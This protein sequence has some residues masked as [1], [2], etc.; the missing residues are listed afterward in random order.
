MARRT[1]FEKAGG[2]YEGYGVGYFEDVDLCFAIA[3]LGYKVFIDTDAQAHHYVGASMK[4]VERP[5]VTFNEMILHTRYPNS[6]RWTDYEI[7]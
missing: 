2:F 5:P 3:K 6:F 1:V 7:Y 4:Q